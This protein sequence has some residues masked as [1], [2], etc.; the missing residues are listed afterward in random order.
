[1]AW[2]A[3]SFCDPYS[4]VFGQQL[5]AARKAY[6]EIR[7]LFQQHAIVIARESRGARSTSRRKPQGQSV[8]PPEHQHRIP[9]ESILNRHSTA[10][11]RAESRTDVRHSTALSIEKRLLDRV[12]VVTHPPTAVRLDVRCS[13]HVIRLSVILTSTM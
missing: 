8:R 12:T 9:I 4:S 7:T 11:E 10:D 3:S 6:Y 2:I 1:M 5:L 13:G